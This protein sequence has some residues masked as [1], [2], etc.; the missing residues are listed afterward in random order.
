MKLPDPPKG[1]SITTPGLMS[2]MLTYS[3]IADLISP[4]WLLLA[5]PM[6]LTAS[7]NE[8]RR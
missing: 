2:I 3:I 7:H 6:F 8:S 5:I 1:I 4:W